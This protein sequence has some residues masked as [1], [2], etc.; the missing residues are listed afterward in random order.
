MCGISN[1][2]LVNEL[3]ECFFCVL[4]EC[5]L[6]LCSGELATTVA[7]AVFARFR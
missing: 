6:Y 3:D 2:T 7:G 5:E 4:C 1:S